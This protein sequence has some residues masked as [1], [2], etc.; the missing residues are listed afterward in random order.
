MA[1]EQHINDII[2]L[3]AQGTDRDEDAFEKALNDYKSELKRCT[4]PSLLRRIALENLFKLPVDSLIE[5]CR[6]FVEIERSAENLEF[7]ADYLYLHGP[8]W[9]EEAGEL[10]QEAERMKKQT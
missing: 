5:T 9:D 7:L 4:S 3:I 2:D 6:R 8:D 1:L 10:L